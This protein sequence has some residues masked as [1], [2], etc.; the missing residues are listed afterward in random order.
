[1]GTSEQTTSE[2]LQ[3]HIQQH[4]ARLVH[5]AWSILG[6]LEAARDVAQDTFLRLCRQDPA[7]VGDPPSAWLYRV[8]RNRALDLYR[9]RKHRPQEHESVL[10]ELPALEADPAEQSGMRERHEAVLGALRTLNEKEQEVVRLKF[11]HDKSYQE[12][13]DITGLKTG[14]VGFILHS[15]LKK[16]RRKLAGQ[17]VAASE[18]RAA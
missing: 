4:E 15:S 8:C 11:L 9:Q 18:Q 3:Q 1:M 5:Y 13:A 7:S 17:E 14:N 10:D 12:I 16:L 2:W 6:D